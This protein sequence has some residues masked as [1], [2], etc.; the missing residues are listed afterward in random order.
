MISDS[1]VVKETMSEEY[2]GKEIKSSNKDIEERNYPHNG[3]GDAYSTET[4]T[5]HN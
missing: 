2:G 5:E 3:Q 4:W 1:M